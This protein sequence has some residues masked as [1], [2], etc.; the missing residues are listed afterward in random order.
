MATVLRA[1]PQARGI[2]FNLSHVIA[3]AGPVLDAQGLTERCA[4][5][6]GD[7]FQAVPAGAG[8]LAT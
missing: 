3:T 4:L 7:F 8:H 2:L 5:V 1:N 6:S